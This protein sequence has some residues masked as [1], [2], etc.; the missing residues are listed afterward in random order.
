VN[1]ERERLA[2]ARAHREHWYRWGPYLADRQWGTVRE[3]YSPDGNAWAYLP[4]DHARSRAYRWGEDGIGGISDNHQ[5]LCL[6]VALWNGN[7]PILKERFFGLSG[8]EGNHGE[9]VKEYYYYLDNTPTHAFMRMLYK[10]PQTAFPYARL[11]AENAQRPRTAPEFELDETGAFDDDRYFDVTIEYAKS[12]PG[13]ILMRVTVANR[14]PRAARIDVL[15]TLWCRNT[16]SWR[17]NAEHPLLAR[18]ADRGTAAVV[19]ADVPELGTVHLYAEHPDDVLFTENET[20][21]ERLFGVANAAPFVKDAFHASVVDGR[22]G[23]VNPAHTGTKAAVRWRR[24]IAAGASTTFLVRLTEG[25]LLEQP[26]GADFDATFER[27]QR[28]ADE[29]YR[30]VTP[31][32][33]GDDAR[34]IQRQ[35]FAG[36]LWSKQWYHFVIRDWLGGDPAAPAPPDGRSTGRNAEWEHLYSDE[37]LSMPDKWEYPWFAAWD[38]AFHV[39]PFAL[40]DPDFAKRQLLNLT[41]E[42][43]MHPSGQLPAYEWAFGDV[44]PP[45]HAWAAYRVFKIDEKLN[46]KADYL[47]LERVFQKLLLNFTWWINRKDRSGRNVFQGGFLGLDNIG[48][49]DRSA[50]LPTGGHLDQ[51]DGTSWMAFFALVMMRI[52][53]ELTKYSRAYEDIASKFFEHFLRIAHAMNELDGMGLWHE[54]DGFYYDVLHLDDGSKTHM[55]VRSLVGLLPLLAVETIEPA[56]LAANPDFAKRMAWFIENR[57]EFKAAVACMETPGLGERR[58]LAIVW[59]SRLKRV[60]ERLFDETE[61]LSDYGVRA[62]SRYHSAHP[63]ALNVGEQ[64]YAIGYEPAESS[65]GLFGGNSN[66]RGPI[67]FPI[68]YLLIEALQK[69][70]HYAGDALTVEIPPG[71][72]NAVSLW[73]AANAIAHRLIAIF[74][75]DEHGRRPVFGGNERMQNDPHWRD[76]V[77]FYEYFH[78]DNG[79]GIGAGHQTGWTALVAK[80]LQQCAE[81]CGEHTDPLR[82]GKLPRLPLPPEPADER[83]S[84]REA[85]GTA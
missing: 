3:D 20:N 26:F 29:F 67:W 66:W 18:C 81:Y 13:D 76:H 33:L 80:L 83:R 6:A 59:P 72:G 85:A 50:P 49:F 54:G 5:R 57:P 11:V 43:F 79:A 78:G 45:V 39:V 84:A 82:G 56:D 12:A 10:Y 52:A 46:G 25:A 24:E 22:A 30:D 64:E 69:Y 28:E 2:G 68:N 48:I 51:S 77:L 31:F 41:R 60:L 38:L 32:A 7:D 34:S 37:I 23:C 75:R 35:A 1:A 63:Y 61:F 53:L 17:P 40:I 65:S 70:H 71:S 14:G 55:R 62:V 42:W 15:P 27:R 44:N 9:D 58:L 74:T 4:H 36:L 16:W 73:D 8:P 21:S 47:F 19:R